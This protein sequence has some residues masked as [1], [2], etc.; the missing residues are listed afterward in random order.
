MAITQL[1]YFEL[2]K[3]LELKKEKY[4]LKSI[5]LTND[6][7]SKLKECFLP[8]ELD[9]YYDVFIETKVTNYKIWKKNLNDWFDYSEKKI[10]KHYSVG[11][12]YEITNYRNGC[13][14]KTIFNEFEIKISLKYSGEDKYVRTIDEYIEFLNSESSERVDYINCF[15][16]FAGIMNYELLIKLRKIKTK[17][18]DFYDSRIYICEIKNNKCILR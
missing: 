2:R 14:I 1:E 12:D 10:N 7:E 5:E 13:A 8:F 4:E 11:N 18:Y 16:Q 17:G 15:E 6:L 9:Y 3:K